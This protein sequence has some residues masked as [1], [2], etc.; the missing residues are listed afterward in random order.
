MQVVGMSSNQPLGQKHGWHIQTALPSE[1]SASMTG[2]GRRAVVV[3]DTP[4]LLMP[5]QHCAELYVLAA[6]LVLDSL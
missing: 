4:I 1:P 3:A 5:H 2:E 6:R